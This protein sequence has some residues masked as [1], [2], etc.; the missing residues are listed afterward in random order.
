MPKPVV[1]L[2]VPG[3]VL[4]PAIGLLIGTGVVPFWHAALCATS[5]AIPGD[6]IG[7]WLSPGSAMGSGTGIGAVWGAPPREPSRCLSVVVIGRRLPVTSGLTSC[8][9]LPQISRG[10]VETLPDRVNEKGER[11]GNQPFVGT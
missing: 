1:G 6:N 11:H 4:L 2:L 8:W 10:C 9:V 5:G 7:Y 3:I